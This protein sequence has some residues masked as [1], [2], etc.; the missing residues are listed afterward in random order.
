MNEKLPI[1]MVK[2]FSADNGKNAVISI[3]AENEFPK[4]PFKGPVKKA[5]RNNQILFS[6]MFNG[7]LTVTSDNI[8]ID[9]S[10]SLHTPKFDMGY[11]IELDY[12]LTIT[13][14]NG[15]WQLN[16]YDKETKKA[17]DFKFHGFMYYG[18]N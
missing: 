9:N 12:I 8:K 14:K 11:E 3:E 7:T 18:G 16:Y 6:K 13:L 4:P 1:D 15:R 10:K 2:Q 17:I 5:M